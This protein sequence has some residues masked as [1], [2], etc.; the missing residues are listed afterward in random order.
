MKG[1]I[2]VIAIY[3]AKRGLLRRKGLR[4]GR[5]LKGKIIGIKY[6]KQ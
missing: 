1:V 5:R 2:Y 3:V 4:I 6:H